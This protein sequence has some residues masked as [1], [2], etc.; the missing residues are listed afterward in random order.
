MAKKAKAKGEG[1]GRLIYTLYRDCL[2]SEGVY[3]NSWQ[4]E[5]GKVVHKGEHVG[6]YS[7]VRRVSCGTRPQNVTQFWLTLFFLGEQPPQNIT[8]H[9]AHAFSLPG[10]GS[11]IGSVSAASSDFKT[12]IGKRFR[13]QHAVPTSGRGCPRFC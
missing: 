10:T 8:L 2:G 12:Y 5:G 11:A 7:I 1:L 4:I 13:T 6:H 9:G 3:G